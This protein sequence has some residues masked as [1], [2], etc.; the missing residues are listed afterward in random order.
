MR[1]VMKVFLLNTQDG[2]WI[3][4][5]LESINPKT[6]VATAAGGCWIAD[7]FFAAAEGCSE[8]HKA[9]YDRLVGPLHL[10]YIAS[11]QFDAFG[12]A[13]IAS[14]P[15]GSFPEPTEEVVAERTIQA[16]TEASRRRRQSITSMLGSGNLMVRFSRDK[17]VSLS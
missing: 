17:Q 8:E 11:A 4:K 10:K 1:D 3:C 12:A 15:E 9:L 14:L 7:K 5:T 13:L 2:E 6:D 16:P